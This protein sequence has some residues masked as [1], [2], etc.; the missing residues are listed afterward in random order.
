FDF[1]K[2][3]N[4]NTA[5]EAWEVCNKALASDDM[6]NRHSEIYSQKVLLLCCQKPK[7]GAFCSSS[8]NIL[9]LFAL[10]Y[11]QASIGIESISV[12]LS[13]SVALN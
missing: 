9:Q 10:K 7:V 6:S 13:C 3:L 2:P 1:H 4:K 8:I 11:L 12:I 5:E